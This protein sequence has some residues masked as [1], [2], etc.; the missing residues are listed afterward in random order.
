MVN[1]NGEKI[2]PLGPCSQP[3]KFSSHPHTLH[4]LNNM[5]FCSRNFVWISLSLPYV[6][7]S[8]PH[9]PNGTGHRNIWWCTNYRK[10]THTCYTQ[11][12][13]Y[14]KIYLFILILCWFFFVIFC[15]SVA[16]TLTTNFR[17]PFIFCF[18]NPYCLLPCVVFAFGNT[19]MLLLLYYNIIC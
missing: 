17:F 1:Q 9:R 7:I 3:R 16:R 2:L 10:C 8:L 6:Q 19:E 18:P 13:E 4:F 5:N 11:D 12:S 15:I 14:L